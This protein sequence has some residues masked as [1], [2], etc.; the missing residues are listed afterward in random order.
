MLLTRAVL[1]IRGKLLN[2][3]APPRLTFPKQNVGSFQT[4]C[5]TRKLYRVQHRV[6]HINDPSMC[7]VTSHSLI[8]AHVDATHLF[9]P[10]SC[11]LLQWHLTCVVAAWIHERV[12]VT[13][14]LGTLFNSVKIQKFSWELWS[15]LRSR[16]W[17]MLLLNALLRHIL[18]LRV[19]LK[20][21]SV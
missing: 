17:W 5:E 6:T 14:T 11:F 20:L 3:E 4:R 10:R 8:T 12:C 13:N 19:Y 18:Y 21:S 9:W 1:L 16:M 7:D 2:N 15:D